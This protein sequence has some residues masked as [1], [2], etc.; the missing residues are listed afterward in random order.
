MKRARAIITHDYTIQ[1]GDGAPIKAALSTKLNTMAEYMRDLP[2]LEKQAFMN[3][4][5]KQK[6]MQRIIDYTLTSMKV[7]NDIKAPKQQ[8]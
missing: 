4:A 2:E 8:L 6:N 3:Y 1:D 7:Y 5:V